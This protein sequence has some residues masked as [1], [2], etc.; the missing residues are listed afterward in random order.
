[1]SQASVDTLLQI[2][3]LDDWTLFGV[4]SENREDFDHL[5]FWLTPLLTDWLFNK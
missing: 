5:N 1:M 2:V 3:L 4:I